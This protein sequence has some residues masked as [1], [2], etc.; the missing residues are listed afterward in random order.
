M[1]SVAVEYRNGEIK[2][3]LVPPQ[4]IIVVTENKGEIDVNIGGIIHRQYK[5]KDVQSITVTD[6]RTNQSKR[7]TF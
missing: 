3:E 4:L 1:K 6:T 5:V 7:Y 2:V